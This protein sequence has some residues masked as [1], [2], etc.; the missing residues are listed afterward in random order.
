[1][2]GTKIGSFTGSLKLEQGLNER[3]GLHSTNG[4]VKF[5]RLDEPFIKARDLRLSIV[6]LQGELKR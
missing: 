6:F 2:H 3:L 4:V 5:F 1:M